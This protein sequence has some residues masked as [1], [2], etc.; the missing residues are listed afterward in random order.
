MIGRAE[1]R[2]KELMADVRRVPGLPFVLTGFSWAL[3]VV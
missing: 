2:D 3:T 1:A